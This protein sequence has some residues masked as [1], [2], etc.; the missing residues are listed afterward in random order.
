MQNPLARQDEQSNENRRKQQSQQNRQQSEQGQNIQRRSDDW[1]QRSGLSRRQSGYSSP[2]SVRPAEFF[3]MS[4]LALMRRFNEDMDRIFECGFSGSEQQDDLGWVPPVEIRQSGNNLIIRAEV[5]GLNESDVRVEATEDGLV[6]EGERRREHT[7]ERGGVHHSEV[8]YGR[9][10][11]LIPLP[12]NAKIEEA[13][14]SFNNG[15]LEVT[16]PVPESERRTRQ[17]PISGQRQ[18]Q[19]ESS[20]ASR[21]GENQSPEG[22]SQTRE[23]QTRAAKA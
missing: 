23:G 11:R 9:F 20:E 13:K 10:R 21:S 17:I 22:Q 18:L 5:P 4:P 14:G 8:A 3:T 15:I 2:F 6:I 16:V 19:G 1:G 7:E 12:E